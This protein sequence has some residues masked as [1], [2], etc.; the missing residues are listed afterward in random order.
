M[1]NF[2]ALERIRQAVEY[3]LVSNYR[4][5]SNKACMQNYKTWTLVCKSNTFQTFEIMFSIYQKVL[6]MSLVLT[7]GDFS[8]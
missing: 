2:T 4:F 1:S 5:Y 6:R 8:S 7:W 3:D